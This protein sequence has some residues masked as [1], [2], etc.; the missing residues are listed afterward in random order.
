MTEYLEVQGPEDEHDPLDAFLG[1]A[2][3]SDRATTISWTPNP[4]PQTEFVES[5]ANEVLYGGA[6]GGGKSAGLIA[7]PLRWTSNPRFRALVLRRETP[8]LEDLLDKAR[9][10]YKTE[11]PAAEY[12][13]DKHTWSFPSGARVRFN[14][15][16]EESDATDYQGHE[17]QLIEFDELTH[18]TLKQYREIISRCRSSDPTLPRFVRATT[19]PGGPGHEW[20]FKRWGAFLDPEFVLEDWVGIVDIVGEDQ[21]LHPVQVRG[22]G[23]PPRRDASG[24]KLPPALGGQILY[25][26]QTRDGERL[27]TTPIE[28]LPPEVVRTRTFIPARLTDNPHLLKNDP[29]YLQQLLDNDP[30]RVKQLTE[31]DWLVRPGAGL[32]F[33]RIWFTFVDEAPTARRRVRYWDKAAT[34]PSDANP[35]PDWTAGLKMSLSDDGSTYCIEDVERFRAGPGVVETTIL[36]TAELDG[37]PVA[38]RMAQDP[39]SAGKSDA[40]AY[41]RKLEGFDIVTKRETGDKVTRAAPAS[42]QAS[43]R[44]TGGEKGR[45]TIVRG[46]WNAI[47]LQEL[48]AFPDGD[49]DDQ[50]DALSGAFDA[51]QDFAAPIP[52]P[53][54]PANPSRWAGFSGRG[55]G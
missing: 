55:F 32:Y 41:T 52:P 9:D 17:Y 37:K 8:Q 27:S 47:L 36:A 19:N 1:A 22:T 5:T 16:K 25:V 11:I 43:P 40:A 13:G 33:K 10:L 24:K 44:S 50:V 21:K 54:P 14:H 18:F 20:V 42:A 6:A 7:L 49:H 29:G 53:K 15:C 26:A 48:E 34:E 51:L 23:A 39:G 31:G 46:P 12:R 38:V 35:D 3:A 2:E 4:G 30:V 45:F 28:G